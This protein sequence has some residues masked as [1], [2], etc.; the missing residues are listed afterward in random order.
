MAQEFT[1]RP[2]SSFSTDELAYNVKSKTFVA[3]ASEL[4][5]SAVSKISYIIWNPA[6]MMS[7]YFKYIKTDVT[8]DGEIAGWRYQ[9]RQG[10]NL[11]IIND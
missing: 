10:I 11:L 2:K 6:T 9:S 3:E 8:P 5:L 1:S 7:Q 4:G